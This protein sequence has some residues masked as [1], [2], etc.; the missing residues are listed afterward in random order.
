MLID[1]GHLFSSWSP[2]G[3]FEHQ[4]AGSPR[5]GHPLFFGITTK[6]VELPCRESECELAFHCI[7]ALLSLSALYLV[8]QNRQNRKIFWT[9]LIFLQPPSELGSLLRKGVEGV[10]VA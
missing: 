4:P 2:C 5:Q 9:F 1:V 10:E 3:C 8:R 6:L 7:V